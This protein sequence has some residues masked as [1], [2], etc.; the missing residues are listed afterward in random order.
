MVLQDQISK[1]LLY[2]VQTLEAPI[3]SQVWDSLEAQQSAGV[4][5]SSSNPADGPTSSAEL[6]GAGRRLS[7]KKLFQPRS[8]KTASQQTSRQG[9]Q[10]TVSTTPEEPNN[11]DTSLLTKH[12]LSGIPSTEIDLANYIVAHGILKKD[13]R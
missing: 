5:R 12:A 6:N 4:R 13:L 3:I 1:C 7:L 8:S 10:Q 9:E 11:D 2:I